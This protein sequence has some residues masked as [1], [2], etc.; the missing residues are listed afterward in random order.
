M[1]GRAWRAPASEH[2]SDVNGRR[3]EQT[4]MVGVSV[5]VRMY[6]KNLHTGGITKK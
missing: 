5:E 4:N 2:A 3:Q 6:G 1:R